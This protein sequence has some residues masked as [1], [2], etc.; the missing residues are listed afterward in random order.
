MTHQ[1]LL[2]VIQ[3]WTHKTSKLAICWLLTQGDNRKEKKKITTRN[4]S[5][6]KMSKTRLCLS[7][8]LLSQENKQCLFCVPQFMES[9][10]KFE[11]N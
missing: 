5:R 7:K 1:K 9:K 10:Y 2:K 8:C 11:G 6:S 3:V 4:L